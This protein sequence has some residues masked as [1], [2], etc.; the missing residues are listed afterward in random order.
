MFFVMHFLKKV[1]RRLKKAN[2]SC[3]IFYSARWVQRLGREILS[4]SWAY[5]TVNS[6]F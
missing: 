6:F 4:G 5:G 1:R 2:L 3:G